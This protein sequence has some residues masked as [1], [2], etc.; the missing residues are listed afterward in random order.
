MR[1]LRGLRGLPHLQEALKGTRGRTGVTGGQHV[2][3]Q[4]ARDGDAEAKLVLVRGKAE[5]LPP[6]KLQRI[7]HEQ[8]DRAGGGSTQDCDLD[9]VVA[10][11]LTNFVPDVVDLCH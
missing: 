4:A 9:L 11:G 8:L 6:G 3:Q 5:A 10:C 7:L 1:R 2:D